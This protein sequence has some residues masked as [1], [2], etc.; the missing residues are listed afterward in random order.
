MEIKKRTLKEKDRGEGLDGQ[1]PQ[2]EWPCCKSDPR[3]KNPPA[4]GGSR[5]VSLHYSVTMCAGML[6]TQV[7]NTHKNGPAERRNTTLHTPTVAQWHVIKKKNKKKE[8]K[9]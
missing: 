4:K 9:K 1:A 8:K 2:C 6:G 5:V 3:H 7:T